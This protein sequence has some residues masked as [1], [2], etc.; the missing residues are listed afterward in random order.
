M[1]ILFLVAVIMGVLFLPVI[2][3]LFAMVIAFF[4]T[5]PQNPMKAIWM[6]FA[7]VGFLAALVTIMSS[8]S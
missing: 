4:N 2:L 6:L 7:I 5:V 3:T 8:G 1:I